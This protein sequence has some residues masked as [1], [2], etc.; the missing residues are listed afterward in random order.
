MKRKEEI[1]TYPE[2]EREFVTLRRAW[3]VAGMVIMVAM[4]AIAG[5]VVGMHVR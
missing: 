4:G 3:Y 2:W 1:R 5:F